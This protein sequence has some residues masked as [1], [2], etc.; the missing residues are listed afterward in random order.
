MAAITN[1]LELYKHL[2][3]TNCGECRVP[4]CMAFAVAVVQ[5][6]KKLRDCPYMTADLQARFDNRIEKRRSLDDDRQAAL[7]RLKEQLA[8]I[9]FKAAASRLGAKLI[10]GRLTVICL[11]K[12]FQLDQ[13]GDL[14]SECH[15]NIW[16]LMPLLHYVIHGQ[17]A[18]PAGNWVL[19]R[20]LPGAVDWGRFFAHRCEESLRQLMDAHAELIFTILELFGAQPPAEAAHADRALVIHPLPKVPFLINYWA[21]EE[22]IDSK[23]NILFDRSAGVNSSPESLYLLGRG[24]VEM[25]RQLI[26]RHNRD[27]KLF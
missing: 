8:G 26:V 20:E 12:D 10:D 5:G 1:P 14:V 3:K 25:F 2:R 9:D 19:F 6:Q 23:L 13:R 18:E 4:S 16:V 15:N 21:P 22:E 24:M 11:G 17:G 7:A 27:G